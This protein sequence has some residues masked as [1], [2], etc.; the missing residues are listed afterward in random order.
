MELLR[1]A[2]EIRAEIDDVWSLVGNFGGLGRWIPEI[3]CTLE[4]DGSGAVRTITYP[5][6][7]VVCERLDALDDHDHVIAYTIVSGSAV[8]VENLSGTIRLR[9]G[10]AAGRTS[11]E[12]VVTATSDNGIDLAEPLMALAGRALDR[13]HRLEQAVRA[14]RRD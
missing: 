12:W 11:V 3:G 4:G 1:M 8:P 14:G 9:P 2:R 7:H 5:D 6:G 13:T 10:S